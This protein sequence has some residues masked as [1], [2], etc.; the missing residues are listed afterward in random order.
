M[1][2]LINKMKKLTIVI[3]MFLPLLGW[4]QEYG[5]SII[6]YG[7]SMISI[8]NAIIIKRNPYS[9]KSLELFARMD[10]T[11]PNDLKEDINMWYDSAMYYKITD[12]CDRSYAFNVHTEQAA[13]IDWIDYDTASAINLPSFT[14]R[15]GYWTNGVDNYIDLNYTPS[16]DACKYTIENASL[17]IYTT[18]DSINSNQTLMG[19][20][21][22]SVSYI[23]TTSTDLFNRVNST[24]FDNYSHNNSLYGLITHSREGDNLLSA[25]NGV[26]FRSIS[27]P[28]SLMLNASISVGAAGGPAPSGFSANRFSFAHVCASLTDVQVLKLYEADT[29]F[30]NITS[31]F[32]EGNSLTEGVAQNSGGKS[33]PELLS[34]T[35][36]YWKVTN[37]G[38]TGATLSDML[39]TT[40]L[41]DGFNKWYK[42]NIAVIWGGVNDITRDSTSTGTH[43]LFDS[44]CMV[45]KN[46]GYK[47]IAVTTLPISRLSQ[48]G[49]QVQDTITAY[50]NLIINNYENYA[51]ALLITGDDFR[52]SDQTNTTYYAIDELHLITEGYRVVKNLLQP[53]IES[54]INE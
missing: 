54:L 49:K 9:N 27:K 8:D 47:V 41:N 18:T 5:Y 35:N 24:N 7:N 12:S 46:R 43:R 13:L 37:S 38:T 32:C 3:L 45:A 11:P 1:D 53:I 28:A 22:A 6:K 20:A 2:K 16:I 29:R 36:T 23:R 52:L 4:G 25:R 26:Y 21:S 48:T 30:M 31:V 40:H 42:D 10:S 34:D 39:N 15:E 14:S 19:G 33:Y 51:D 44:L 17:S 50:N